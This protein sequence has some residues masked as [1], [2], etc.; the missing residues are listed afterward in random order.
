M[1]SMS[2]SFEEAC[3]LYIATFYLTFL[4]WEVGS[5]AFYAYFMHQIDKVIN[6]FISECN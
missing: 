3:V 2:Q 5:T 6:Y 1:F 4:N